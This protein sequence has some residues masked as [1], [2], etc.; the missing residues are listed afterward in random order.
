MAHDNPYW[1]GRMIQLFNAQDKDNDKLNARMQKEYQRVGANIDKEV[2]FCYS[3]YGTDDVIEYRKMLVSLT[4]A[5]RDLLYK[6]ME[7]FAIKYPQY[8]DLMPV[9]ESIYQLNRLEGLQLSVRQNMLELGAIEQEEFDKA[10]ASAYDR[11]YLSSMKGLENPQTFF[12]VDPLIMQ[13]TINAPWIDGK[14]FSDR[15]WDNKERLIR[16]MNNEIRDG[17]IRGDS[18]RKMTKVIE[19]RTGIGG[20]D[21]KRL[22][23]TE[24]A[25]VLNSAN[26]QAFMDA[27]ILEYEITAVM[28]GRTSP[29]CRHMDGE[30]FK[31]S[32]RVVGFNAPPFHSYCRST[33]IPREN[34][35]VKVADKADS[36]YNSSEKISFDKVT[37]GV[38]FDKSRRTIA[39]KV[40]HNLGLDDIPISVKKIDDRGFCGIATTD[41]KAQITRYV[42]NSADERRTSYQIKTLFHEAYHAANHNR[43]IDWKTGNFNKISWLEIEETFAETSSHFAAKQAGIVETLS[44]AYADK[45]VNTLPRLKQTE[46]FKNARYLHEFGEIAW[47]KR[48]NGQSSTWEPLANELSNIEHDWKKYGLKYK[49]FI[50][51]NEELVFDLIYGNM[52]AYN[53]PHYHSA[54]KKDLSSALSKAENNQELSPNEEF[55]YSNVLINAMN[56]KGVK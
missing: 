8:A 32:E 22:L 33:I 45:L 25:F 6:N 39:K 44:P 34:T 36:S 28:D 26:A 17:L 3:K 2:A 30:V 23:M 14:N 48:L 1:E 27:G 41:G 38:D 37:E 5:E 10:L 7:A 12:K 42:L 9:R 43:G 24:A 29:T 18:Y 52:P 20:S 21:A 46:T 35:Q 16:T 31:F 50:E 13:Q 55:V 56:M 47:E 11:G 51:T 54:F 40:L 15:I 4:S 53:Q 19:N 49:E